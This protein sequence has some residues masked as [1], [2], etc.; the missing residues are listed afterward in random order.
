MEGSPLPE[1]VTLVAPW[2][3][4]LSRENRADQLLTCTFE[5]CR[6]GPEAY[7]YMWVWALTHVCVYA[8]MSMQVW[9]AARAYPW[10]RVGMW[11]HMNTCACGGRLG[12]HVHTREH[13]CTC[14]PGAQFQPSVF[15]RVCLPT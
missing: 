10:A 14:V 3:M 9:T 2:A 1:E 5:A 13:A 12:T 4:A 15:M 8:Y 11:S 6:Q 7:S